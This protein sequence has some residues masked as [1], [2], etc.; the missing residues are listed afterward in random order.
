MKLIGK[1]GSVLLFIFG[2]ALIFSAKVDANTMT[3]AVQIGTTIESVTVKVGETV[4]LTTGG[5]AQVLAFREGGKVL[6]KFLAGGTS[7]VPFSLI[8]LRKLF[9]KRQKNKA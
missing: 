1:L 7:V 5:E 8:A 3:K 2:I 6:L 4:P 9:A